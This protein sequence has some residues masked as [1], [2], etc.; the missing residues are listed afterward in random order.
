MRADAGVAH[1]VCGVGCL[2]VVIGV[3]TG[4]WLPDTPMYARFLG[5]GEKVALSKY[6]AVNRREFVIRGSRLG[7]CLKLS[8]MCR[9][10][11]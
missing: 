6:F 5:K 2:T 11:L 7:R 3:M 8:L 9:C 10:G 4:V 1:H